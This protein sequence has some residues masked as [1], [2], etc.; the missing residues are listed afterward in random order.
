MKW[1]VIDHKF[2]LLYRLVRNI[3]GDILYAIDRKHATAVISVT[4]KI[5]G[6]P[7]SLLIENQDFEV[8]CDSTNLFLLLT[9]EFVIQL[10]QEIEIKTQDNSAN[11]FKKLKARCKPKGKIL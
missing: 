1:L 3:N 2:Y 4:H 6:Q 8:V 7:S 5:I 9:K 10:S 11:N